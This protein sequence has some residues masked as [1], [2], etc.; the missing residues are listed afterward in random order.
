MADDHF[1]PGQAG[2]HEDQMMEMMRGMER[3]LQRILDNQE[4][5]HGRDLEDQTQHQPQHSLP[6]HLSLPLASQTGRRPGQN[7]RR[8]GLWVRFPEITK[9]RR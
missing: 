8:S 6:P 5:Y 2:Q 1:P 4:R 7:T 3:M 9:N